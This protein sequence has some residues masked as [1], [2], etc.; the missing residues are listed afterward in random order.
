VIPCS[1]KNGDFCR[2]TIAEADS[3]RQKQCG[4][5]CAGEKPDDD[6]RADQESMRITC[7]VDHMANFGDKLRAFRARRK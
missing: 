4:A 1:G 5:L 2:E 3:V 7:M 6:A